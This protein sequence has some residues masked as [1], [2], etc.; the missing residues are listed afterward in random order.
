MKEQAQKQEINDK[1]REEYEIQRRKS[2][3]NKIAELKRELEI[4]KSKNSF[5]PLYMDKHV[6]R[7]LQRTLR[8][9]AIRR[10]MIQK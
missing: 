7:D 3:Q 4:E 8:E 10:E 2:D 5:N 1:V 9:N 6:S